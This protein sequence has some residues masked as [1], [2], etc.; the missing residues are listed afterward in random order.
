MLTLIETNEQLA[1][2]MSKHQRAVLLTRRTLAMGG[3]NGSSNG[4]TPNRSPEPGNG[5]VAPPPGPPPNSSKP[6]PA[7]P[8]RNAVSAA[9]QPVP[10]EAPIP[11]KRESA[12]PEL[13]SSQKPE[14]PFKD[15]APSATQNQ[16][17]PAN[18]RPPSDQFHVSQGVEPYH[19]G[20]NP[21]QS[22]MGRQESA[23]GKVALSGAVPATPEAEDTAKEVVTHHHAHAHEEEDAYD[24]SPVQS[25]APIYR[26]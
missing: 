3:E 24:A 8:P 14:D 6:P 15:P 11:V 18:G 12:S 2:A 19:P 25:K 17:F 13:G 7:M 16:P 1:L 26:Y 23:I 22:Y 21:T 10:Q 20:F 5:Y 9:S 4:P